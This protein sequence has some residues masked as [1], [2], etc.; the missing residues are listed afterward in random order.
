MNVSRAKVACSNCP[1][2]C[3]VMVTSLN[4]HHFPSIPGINS[5]EEGLTQN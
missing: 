5:G 4:T 3:I 2:T 1:R